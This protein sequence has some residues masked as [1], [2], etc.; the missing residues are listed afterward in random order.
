MARLVT[1]GMLVVMT[2]DVP[3]GMTMERIGGVLDVP[4]GKPVSI[5][6]PDPSDSM[7]DIKGS[8]DVPPTGILV[9]NV[10]I[11]P[12]FELPNPFRLT[13][14]LV[15]SI[16]DVEEAMKESATKSKSPLMIELA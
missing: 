9:V 6:K 15:R 2:S 12:A 13:P 7:D 1:K 14:P 16:I 11:S 5:V 4:I 3:E 10:G 8:S